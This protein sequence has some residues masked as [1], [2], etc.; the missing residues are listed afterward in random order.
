M[1]GVA[2]C[3]VTHMVT[4]TGESSHGHMRQRSGSS[5]SRGLRATTL[6][7]TL[8]S[9]LMQVPTAFSCL[10]CV[11]VTLYSVA[12]MKNTHTNHTHTNILNNGG[13]RPV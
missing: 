12:N 4:A 10:I 1:H 11:Q 8:T 7:S 13:K 5:T 9:L 6:L 3:P 2:H